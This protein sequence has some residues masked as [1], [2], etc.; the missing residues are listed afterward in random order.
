[1][2]VPQLI[3][4]EGIPG[5]GK[6]SAGEFVQGLLQ[7]Q[8][9]VVRFWREGDF[10]H[11]ADFEGIA[12]LSEATYQDLL[13]RYPYLA[14]LLQTHLTV[15]GADYLLSYRKLQH[16]YPEAMPPALVDEL[17]RRDVYD[18]LPIAPVEVSASPRDPG[19]SGV[20]CW[21]TQPVPDAI[22][23]LRTGGTRVH[24]DVVL[25]SAVTDPEGRYLCINDW[26]V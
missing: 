22:V 13:A 2:S 9:L 10:D 14:D 7:R 18:G 21:G 25:Q 11:P 23:E 19:V 5:S 1:M 16:N 6:S 3:L 12:G 15:R 20:A 26:H 8:G 4:I 17:A 24:P